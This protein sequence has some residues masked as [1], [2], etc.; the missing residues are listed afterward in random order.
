MDLA[1]HQNGYT[2]QEIVRQQKI[3]K[4]ALTSLSLKGAEHKKWFRDLRDRVWVFSG[5]GTSYY[6]AQTGSSLF[7]MITGLRTRAVPASEILTYP[8]LVFNQQEQHVLMAIS[9]SGT[10]TEIVRAVQ[11]TKR[12]LDIPVISISCNGQSPLAQEGQ[13]R[14]LFP[15]QPEQ[16][17]VMTGSFTTML[18]SIVHMALQSK[19]SDALMESLA[20][21][22]GIS[23]KVM[24]EH[25]KTVVQVASS[26]VTDFVFLAQGPYLGIANEASLKMKEM[27]ISSSVSFHA[28]EFRHGPMSVVTENT[29]ITILL[30][31]SGEKY[32]LSLAEDMKKMGAKVLLLGAAN[33]LESDNKADFYIQVP[34]GFGDVFNSFLFMPILQLLGF[35]H[36]IHKGINPDQPKNLTA[37]VK[38]ND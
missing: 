22:S 25:E 32:E 10:T 13:Y 33:G 6:L 16:S 12:E 29:L 24:Q 17:V 38:L 14:L 5:C 2:Y 11:K 3:W 9:R 34:G 18:L 27:S 15:F 31:Q 30:S 21:I 19:Q 7:E 4:E 23:E 1:N 35:Y 36:A 20:E 8:G 28:L 37:V 26:G